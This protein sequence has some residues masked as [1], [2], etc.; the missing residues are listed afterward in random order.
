MELNIGEE[1]ESKTKSNP[2]D[3]DDKAGSRDGEDKD[4]IRRAIAGTRKNLFKVDETCTPDGKE[5]NGEKTRKPKG[6]KPISKAA[7]TATPQGQAQTSGKKGAKFAEGTQ[8]H[9]KVCTGGAK[10]TP[11]KEGK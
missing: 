9:K 11:G 2:K 7:T 6:W 1:E 8:F 4:S 10:K 5:E 3:S